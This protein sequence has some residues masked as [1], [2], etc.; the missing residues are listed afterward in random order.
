MVMRQTTGFPEKSLWKALYA[1][2]PENQGGT[3]VRLDLPFGFTPEVMNLINKGTTF[4]HSIKAIN[5]DKLRPDAVMPN[6]AEEVLKER[7]M[8]AP[9]GQVEALPDSAFN[10]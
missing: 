3:K 6:F 9:V 4:L 5:V 1:T 7:G 8:K 10:G 2:Y